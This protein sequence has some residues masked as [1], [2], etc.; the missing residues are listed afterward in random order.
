MLTHDRQ[1]PTE[2]IHGVRQLLC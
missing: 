1:K 2:V